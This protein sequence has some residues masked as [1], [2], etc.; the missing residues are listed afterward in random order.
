[1]NTKSLTIKVSFPIFKYASQVTHFTPRTPTVIERMILRLVYDY[2]N[3]PT[4]GSTAL[5]NIFEEHLGVANAIELVIPSIDD[6]VVLGVLER[7]QKEIEEMSVA[8]FHL[9]DRGGDFYRR[10]QL[11]GQP[12]EERV[13]HLFDSLNYTWSAFKKTTPKQSLISAIEL[14]EESFTPGNA[15]EE[16]R[17]CL[18]SEDY[19]WKKT[20]TEI[21]NIDSELNEK[22]QNLQNLKLTVNKGGNLFLE[23]DENQKALQQWLKQVKPEYI[24]EAIL[25][26]AFLNSEHT[27]D[28][29]QLEANS[30][31]NAITTCPVSSLDISRTIKNCLPETPFFMIGLHDHFAFDDIEKTQ[32]TLS[33][34]L[35]EPILWA[36]DNK[37]FKAQ[38]NIPE[39]LPKELLALIFPS[40]GVSP[41]AVFLGEANLYWAG[42]PVKGLVITQQS[43]GEVGSIW[44]GIQGHLEKSI[45]ESYDPRVSALAL[46]WNSPEIVIGEWLDCYSQDSLEK[47]LQFGL[48]FEQAIYQV[49]GEKR[50]L[51]RQWQELFF[52]KL[53][54]KIDSIKSFEYS[55]LC[56][57]IV[58]INRQLPDFTSQLHQAL[59][60]KLQP[61][62]KHNELLELRKLVG[63]SFKFPETLID[64]ELVIYWVNCIL[65]GK[66]ID[67]AAPHA[68][69]ESL[70]QCE[71]HSQELMRHVSQ[72]ALD[73]ATDEGRIATG[74]ISIKS[75]ETAKQWIKITDEWHEYSEYVFLYSNLKPLKEQVKNW[76]EHVEIYM[77]EPLLGFKKWVVFDTSALMDA[78]NILDQLGKNM[79]LAVPL[80]V[81]DEL[82]KLK[83]D[84]RE[85]YKERAITAQKVIKKI[86]ALADSITEVKYI[87]E[88]LPYE[89]S[90]DPTSDDMII[91]A[92]RSLAL[93][94]MVLVSSDINFRNKAK[95]LEVNVMATHDFSKKPSNTSQ[96]QAR[97]NN[98]K[99]KK[100]RKGKKNEL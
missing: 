21:Q 5:L 97:T 75:L 73:M 42:Q 13:E 57:L 35:P 70:K 92:A 50:D 32:L 77:H 98:K 63:S 45:K 89:Y 69:V 85:E 60:T 95:S 46:F 43:E 39:R 94:P 3:E 100:T 76:K 93:S 83:Q 33:E 2:R 41:I 15:N 27:P 82:D 54:E 23:A 20:D 68:W 10:N 80:M 38:I 44:K 11:P 36:T 31:K 87:P 25:T 1:M 79:Q 6:L 53:I 52:E 4:I 56:N 65:S 96:T 30:L 55:D 22:Q 51:S 90:K 99:S 28:W 16:V 48:E 34:G 86:E 14:N 81:L 9:S 49:L 74:S 19:P 84:K 72:K 78:P 17:R 58:T 91:S 26:P 62:K 29:P 12:K 37:P 64:V 24:R 8:E 47:L 59:L 7:P 18:E 88:L 71:E 67:L 40:Q 61:I 66:D